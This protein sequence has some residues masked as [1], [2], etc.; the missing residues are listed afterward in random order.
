MKKS[1]YI[2]I[3]FLV[4]LVI[5]VTGGTWTANQFGYKP[6]LG[7]SGAAEKNVFD[8]GL[9]R[10][11]TRLG[12]EI[13]VGDQ[14]YGA[15]LQT[16]IAAI[17]SNNA[18]LR[19]P[20]GPHNIAADLSIPANVSLKAERG[21]VLAVATGKTLTINGPLEAGPYQIFSC[22]GTGQVVFGPG[23]VKEAYGEWWGAKGDGATDDTAAFTAAMKALNTTVSGKTYGGTIRVLS[24]RYKLNLLIN[25]NNIAFAGSAGGL[26]SAS[27]S[28][29][30]IPYDINT[31]LLQIGNDTQG[32]KGIRF[33]NLLFQANGGKYGIYCYGGA[34][35]VY[36]NDVVIM[37]FLE[38]CFKI[39]A[40]MTY[41]AEY[42]FF[43]N[44]YIHAYDG[45]GASQ[46]TIYAVP[47][48]QGS[49]SWSTPIFFNNGV[50]MGPNDGY[51][52]E[53]DGGG[54]TFTN[55][56][57]QTQKNHSI[58]FSNSIGGTSYPTMY[59]SGV[60]I[61]ASG[62]VDN[63]SFAPTA[64]NAGTDI[65]TTTTDWLEGMPVTFSNTGGALP[66]PLVAGTTYYVRRQSSSAIKVATV[67]SG[68]A[69]DLTSQGTGTH[70]ISEYGCGVAV[71]HFSDNFKN[72]DSFMKGNYAVTGKI[73]WPSFVSGLFSGYGA[74]ANKTGLTNPFVQGELR[75]RGSEFWNYPDS[76]NLKIYAS[77]GSGFIESSGGAIYLNASTGVCL[78]NDPATA[79][80]IL[81]LPKITTTTATPASLKYSYLTDNY[82][83]HVEVIVTAKCTGGTAGN[84]GKGGSWKV[85]GTF[86]RNSGGYATLIGSVTAIHAQTDVPA[87][88]VTL[89]PSSST[90]NYINV[91]VTGAANDTIDWQGKMEY[92]IVN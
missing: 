11:D 55:T 35:D 56:W 38:Y 85:A 64:V 31:P 19:V 70:R 69:I 32:V 61:E 28:G 88:S 24:K 34:E 66:A 78:T 80:V 6:S 30:L 8:A 21:A 90:S 10:I 27:A 39:K 63:E 57:F 4:L 62:A 75:F 50:I 77:G 52:L 43:N 87:W 7:A 53:L 44:F 14:N 60:G 59:C 81:F 2:A 13:W 91:K 71:E 12:K 74:V 33:S 92:V 67:P 36:F 51:A 15:S 58:K 20:P 9:D 73:K 42:I 84:S 41:P 72:I 76:P 23:A 3:L 47:R 89:E 1:Q 17:G 48:D 45:A 25:Q 16:A 86:K 65:I 68:T 79:P 83:Y 40:G 18:T 82:T 26:P 37:S 49:T 46:R 22:T 29:A 5:A 54:F